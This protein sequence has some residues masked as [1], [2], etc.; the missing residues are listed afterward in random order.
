M[1]GSSASQ[2]PGVVSRAIGWLIAIAL[3]PSRIDFYGERTGRYIPIGARH[4]R[5]PA[6]CRPG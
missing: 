5:Q 1:I 4:E 2:F 6:A 3:P